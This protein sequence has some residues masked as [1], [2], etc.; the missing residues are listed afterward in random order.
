M[1]YLPMSENGLRKISVK[2]KPFVFGVLISLICIPN[3]LFAE[4]NIFL[5]LP[6]DRVYDG[7]T[8][9]THISED[10]LPPPL[11]KLSVRIYGIDTPERGGKAK[12]PKEAELAE[13]ARD[14]LIVLI[15]DEKVMKIKDFKWDK[16]GSRILAHVY[17]KNID[18]AKSLIDGG[19]AVPYFGEKKEKNW[20]E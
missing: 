6:I 18:V 19:F 10:K 4:T 17:V 5:E 20:C 12:C 15:G 8:I 11:N 1:I 7:D 16:F 3:F 2:F 13:K 14:F 9:I